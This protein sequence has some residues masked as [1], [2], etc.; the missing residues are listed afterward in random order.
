VIFTQ[1]SNFTLGGTWWFHELPNGIE[2]DLELRV[3]LTF[4]LSDFLSEF[5]MIEK[6]LP[7]LTESAHDLDIDLDSSLALKDAGKHGN[8]VFGKS[9]RAVFDICALFQDHNL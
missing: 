3:V 5:R 6:H 8:A 4:E 7:E 2:D 1:K 9:I